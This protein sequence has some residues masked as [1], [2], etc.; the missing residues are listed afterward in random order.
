MMD[1]LS[2]M[3][4]TGVGFQGTILI[5]PPLPGSGETEPHATPLFTCL[6]CVT[7]PPARITTPTQ[8]PSFPRPSCSFLTIDSYCKEN[9]INF[10]SFH[11]LS[12]LF[13]HKLFT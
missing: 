5:Y 10:L 4:A 8:L 9:M 13:G 1:T 7:H 12:N 2:A 3:E 6:P 11:I